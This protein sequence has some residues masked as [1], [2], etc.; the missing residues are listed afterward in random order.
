M[1]PIAVLAVLATLAAAPAPAQ[2]AA[3]PPTVT[4]TGTGE[5][6]AVPD[7]AHLSAGV[8][9]TNGTAAE[10]LA[11]N[12]E[13]MTRVIAAL[14]EAGLGDRDIATSG[15]SVDPVHERT[16]DG[17]RGPG[18]DH[19]R[20]VNEV[21]VRTQGLDRLGVLI[22]AVTRAGANRMNG[23]TF[24]LSDPAAAM[25]EARAAA[26]AEARAAAEAYAGAEGLAPGRVVSIRDTGGRPSPMPRGRGFA[27]EAAAAPPV[28]RGDLA[29]TAGV[30]VV[31]TLVPAE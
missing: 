25:A 4:V 24:A 7:T 20:V 18:I 29:V 8:E 17:R 14:R 13:A 2:E 5:T 6:R 12:S 19:Y 16:G 22:D 28:E 3:G 26:M 27:L 1:R 21:R 31:W 15:L 30:T 9:T 11:A 10:A 23:L